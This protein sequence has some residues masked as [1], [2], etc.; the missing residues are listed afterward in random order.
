MIIVELTKC[1]VIKLAPVVSLE[2][3]N[4]APKL[5]AGKRMERHDVLGNLGLVPQGKGLDE[6]GK[7]I[8]K[9]EIVLKTSE[10]C[11]RGCPDITMNQFK[12]CN[13]SM[14]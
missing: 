13:C 7:I 4:C 6:M 10:T 14:L 11:N 12:R 2:G 9:N 3:T 1:R 5:R 8:K